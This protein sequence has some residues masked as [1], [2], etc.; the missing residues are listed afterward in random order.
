MSMPSTT[1]GLNGLKAESVSDGSS[2]SN[3][4]RQMFRALSVVIL[5]QLYEIMKNLN[6][7]GISILFVLFSV[8]YIVSTIVANKVERPTHMEKVS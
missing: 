5:I 2:F 4:W 6:L 1:A 7:F 8:M 3:L